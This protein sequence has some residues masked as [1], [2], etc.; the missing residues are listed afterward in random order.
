MRTTNWDQL[1]D[2]VVAEVTRFCGTR[3]G[4]VTCSAGPPPY[5]R[6]DC[7]GRAL[8]YIRARPRKR[9]VRI[10][11]SGLWRAPA[12]GRLAQPIAAGASALIV[13][14]EEDVPEVVRYLTETIEGTRRARLPKSA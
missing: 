6:L 10:D 14:S 7:D 4:I 12:E 13:R 11:V 1:I 8:A 5:R 2:F 3:E 9:F